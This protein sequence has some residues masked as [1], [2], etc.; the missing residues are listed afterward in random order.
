[1][2]FLGSLFGILGFGIG[3]LIGLVI[4]FYLFIYSEPEDVQVIMSTTIPLFFNPCMLIISICLC[5]FIEFVCLHHQ[6]KNSVLFSGKNK[7]YEFT[8]D[9]PEL[10]HH[11]IVYCDSSVFLPRET[12][13]SLQ[14]D[15]VFY[16]HCIF[17]VYHCLCFN[18]FGLG[19]VVVIYFVII[20]K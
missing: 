18:I 4:G 3:S 5:I 13:S 12:L 11:L 1:M 17:S 14:T 20:T 7:C 9:S 10:L 15:I 8:D 6:M 19:W 16:L 2:G